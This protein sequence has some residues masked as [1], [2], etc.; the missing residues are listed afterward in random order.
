M[1]F[2]QQL[3]LVTGMSAATAFAKCYTSKEK[4]VEWANRNDA[5]NSVRGVCQGFAGEFELKEEK[6]VCVEAG[7]QKY[8]FR[9]MMD[10]DPD[11]NH[12]YHLNYQ[13]CVDRFSVNVEACTRGG[14][15]NNKAMTFM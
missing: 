5:K 11:N 10:Q 4:S 6:K 3:L 2:S 1:L 15:T 12:R 7:G 13:E 9:A 14:I 8:S